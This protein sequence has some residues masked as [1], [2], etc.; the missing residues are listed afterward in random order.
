MGNSIYKT[1][2][3]LLA[4]F[5]VLFITKHFVIDIFFIP[6]DSMRDTLKEGDYIMVSKLPWR[7]SHRSSIEKAKGKILVFKFYESSKTYYVK[8]CIGI[9]GDTLQI[10][11]LMTSYSKEIPTI[12]NYC[13]IWFND[14]PI[15]REHLLKYNVELFGVGYSKKKDH[16]SLFLNNGEIAKLLRIESVDSITLDRFREPLTFKKEKNWLEKISKNENHQEYILPFKHFKIQLNEESFRLYGNTINK[17]EGSKISYENGQFLIDGKETKFYKFKKGYVFM[18]GDNRQLSRDSR[19]V[20]P[21][22]TQNI[23]GNLISKI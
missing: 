13:N 9:P 7:L 8:R 22:P 5:I 10:D 14:Y 6:S 4:F 1:V 15:L 20:G 3:Y 23:V 17:Y 19:F 12:R 18:V 21:I 11:F 16:V 2:K